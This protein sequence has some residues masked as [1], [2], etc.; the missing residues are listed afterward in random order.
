MLR[1]H[2]D[3]PAMELSQSLLSPRD[4]LAELSRARPGVWR[5]GGRTLQVDRPPPVVRRERPGRRIHCTSC[6]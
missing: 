3:W 5:V 4:V 1:W 2:G 6:C